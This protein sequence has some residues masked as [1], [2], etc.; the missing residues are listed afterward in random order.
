MPY[1]NNNNICVTFSVRRWFERARVEMGRAGTT[2]FRRH[3][4]AE[5]ILAKWDFRFGAGVGLDGVGRTGCGTHPRFVCKRLVRAER[6]RIA[7]S[8]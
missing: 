3:R 2:A 8:D 5:F 7:A 6:V 4:M 1:Y